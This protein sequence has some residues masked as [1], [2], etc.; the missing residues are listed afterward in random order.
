MESKLTFGLFLQK[1]GNDDACLEKLLSLKYPNGVYCEKCQKVTRFTKVKSRPV[2]QCSCGYQIS[3]LSGTIF[4]KTTTPLQYWFY[5]IFV[6]SNTRS[7]ISAKQIQREIGVTYKTAWRMCHQVRILMAET[8][9]GLLTGTVEVDET[10]VGGKG[11]NRRNVWSDGFEKPKEALMGMVQRE[12]K[13]YIKHISNTGKWTLLDQIKNNIDPKARILTDEYKSYYHLFK[14]G[15]NHESV[16]HHQGEYVRNDIHTQ[17][18]ENVWSHLKRG[19]TGVY[20]VVSKKYLQAY[21][22]EY[23]FRY[24][25]RK[26]NTPMFDLLLNQVVQVKLLKV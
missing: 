22:D 18:I 3:P 10:Y 13:V 6:M 14:F 2:Y 19:L 25:H 24:N 12:G 26:E 8:G 5:V 21:A 16:N 4:E 1:Y 23:A 9:G 17:N 20:R 7:G 11:K 15:Y